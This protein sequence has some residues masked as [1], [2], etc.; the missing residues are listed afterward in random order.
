MCVADAEFQRLN[1]TTQ[2]AFSSV[3]IDTCSAVSRIS[4]NIYEGVMNFTSNTVQWTH[5]DQMN[6]YENIWFFGMNTTNFTALNRLFRDHSAILYW[7]FEVVYTSNPSMMRSTSALNF[8][9]NQSPRN[10]SCSIDP[11]NGTTNSLFT[12][13]CPHWFDED[14]IED[15]SLYTYSTDLSPGSIWHS[16]QQ[17]NFKFVYQLD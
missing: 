15:Y 1:P 12:I 8:V 6:L 10:G 13:S 5:Y 2:M 11:L 16:V 3:C 14:G 17:H 4:W 9:I 7:R